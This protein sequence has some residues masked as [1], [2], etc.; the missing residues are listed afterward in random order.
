MKYAFRNLIFLLVISLIL[1]CIE[2]PQASLEE[3]PFTVSSSELE[4]LKPTGPF[5]ITTSLLEAPILN[6]PV[7]LVVNVTSITNA[8]DTSIEIRT[9][10]GIIIIKGDPFI[11]KKKISKSEITLIEITLKAIKT[12]YQE[13]AVIASRNETLEFG[14][15]SVSLYLDV[16]E[17]STKVSKR[18]LQ[19]PPTPKPKRQT[20]RYYLKLHVSGTPYLDNSVELTVTAA[21]IVDQ[22]KAAINLFLPEGFEVIE[23]SLKWKGTIPKFP[24][25]EAKITDEDFRKEIAK[26]RQPMDIIFD[27]I[28]TDKQVQFK[29]KIKAVKT[30]DW[31]IAALPFEERPYAVECYGIDNPVKIKKEDAW[32]R[33]TVGGCL[34]IRVQ[35][36]TAIVSEMP[37]P[38]EYKVVEGNLTEEEK[39]KA[40]P[41]P[42]QTAPVNVSG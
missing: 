28:P 35:N 21:S 26:G 37:I 24:T 15:N 36:D 40:I 17:K 32:E 19:P 30:G 10:D 39:A 9:T 38:P 31:Q 18:P 4:S 6:K 2:K 7:K 42:A 3:Y 23:G 13:I 1:G 27:Y 14:R 29:V 8:T 16:S 5:K 25:G 22:Q 12:G 33:Y 20:E 34:N 11:R 41:A